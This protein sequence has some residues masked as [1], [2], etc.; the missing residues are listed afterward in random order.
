MR[1]SNEFPRETVTE[2]LGRARQGDAAASNDLFERVY[3]ELKR[4]AHAQL[5]LRGRAGATLGTTALVH[6]AY[7][8]LVAPSG[9]NAT[10]REHFFNLAAR[11]MRNVLVDFSRRRDAEKRGG[12]FIR[13]DLEEENLPVEDATELGIDLLSLDRA[14]TAL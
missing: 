4:L 2:L 13:V 3:A 12:E 6:E 9:M 14:L 11:V 8:R 10:D 5:S 7:M 1:E